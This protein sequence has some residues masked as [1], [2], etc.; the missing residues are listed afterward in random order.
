MVRYS[1]PCE[2][3]FSWQQRK[4]K[5][6]CREMLGKTTQ[7]QQWPSQTTSRDKL[8][9]QLVPGSRSPTVIPRICFS[10]CPSLELHGRS[11]WSLTA[12]RQSLISLFWCPFFAVFFLSPK[13]FLSHKMSVS[14]CWKQNCSCRSQTEG[15]WAEVE[16]LLEE[17]KAADHHWSLQVPWRAESHFPVYA[18]Y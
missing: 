14:S 6:S 13:V 16:L 10:S 12:V 1:H 18:L 9:S 15:M 8:L 2:A 17:E 7:E 3:I 4:S 5:K 11:C